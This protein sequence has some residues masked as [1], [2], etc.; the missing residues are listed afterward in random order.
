MCFGRGDDEELR[1]ILE[2]L[3]ADFALTHTV[4]EW[5]R[6][7]T[8][9]GVD[10]PVAVQQALGTAGTALADQLGQAIHKG[11]LRDI[12]RLIPRLAVA[13]YPEEPLQAQRGLVAC[14]WSSRSARQSTHRGHPPGWC[15]VSCRLSG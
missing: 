4:A 10:G 11:R 7:C 9:E 2:L 14:G 1:R 13:L 6:L 12:E 8:G 3:P 5:R 15:S